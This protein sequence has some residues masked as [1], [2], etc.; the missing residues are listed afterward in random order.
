MATEE[1]HPI[2]GPHHMAA[3]VATEHRLLT[4]EPHQAEVII[5]QLHPLLPGAAVTH[6]QLTVTHLQLIAP[7][8]H[9]SLELHLPPELHRSP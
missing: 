6:L 7:R 4:V 1:H 3:E 9:L 8:L 2:M 5:P